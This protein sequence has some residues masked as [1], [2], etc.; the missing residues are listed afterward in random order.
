MTNND[1]QTLDRELRIEQF[2]PK[3]NSDALDGYVVSAPID[4][5]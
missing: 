3:K 2:K 4:I 5:I 1:P